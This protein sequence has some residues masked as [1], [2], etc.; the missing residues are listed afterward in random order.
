[1]K[2]IT[3]TVIVISCFATGCQGQ[4]GKTNTQVMT[5]GKKITQK[6][7]NSNSATVKKEGKL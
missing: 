6:T 7:A 5:T 4:S 2:F 3:L 1:M